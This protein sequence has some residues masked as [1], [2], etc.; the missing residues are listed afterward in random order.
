MWTKNFQMYKLDLEKTEEPEIK[1]PISIE[2]WKKQE[3]SRKTSNAASLTTLKP[4]TGC[5]TANCGKFF[6]RWEYQTTWPAS[7]ELCR[8]VKKQQLN[9]DI[10]QQTGERSTLRSYIV[11]CLFNLYAEYIM[12]NTKL[13]EAQA[14]IKIPRRNISN[15]ICRW[16]YPY[17]RK[18]R[19]NKEPLVESEKGRGQNIWGW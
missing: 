6:K 1:W 3:S 10:E 2:S 5:I 18:Q 17:V 4:L 13:D 16:H 15:L 19:K 7:W 9:L 8:Q 14:G 12:Q 11:T